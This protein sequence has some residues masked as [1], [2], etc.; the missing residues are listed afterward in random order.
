MQLLKLMETDIFMQFIEL[1]LIDMTCTWKLV[2][3]N[4]QHLSQ[5]ILMEFMIIWTTHWLVILTAWVIQV[6]T[7]LEI[8]FQ[9]FQSSQIQFTTQISQLTLLAFLQ[10]N[11]KHLFLTSLANLVIICQIMIWNVW[12]LHF[13]QM[14]T[15]TFTQ[16]SKQLFQ[17]L[18]LLMERIKQRLMHTMHNLHLLILMV[19]VITSFQAWSIL[20]K[21]ALL[22]LNIQLIQQR[23]IH[24][25]S[26][27][28]TH[29][30]TEQQI[31]LMM[32]LLTALKQ[33]LLNLH[34]KKFNISIWISAQQETTMVLKD[35]LIIQ[36]LLLVQQHLLQ[37]F[38]IE[39]LQVLHIMETPM[40]QCSIQNM[41][42]FQLVLTWLKFLHT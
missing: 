10:D 30:M 42:H 7:S 28:Q 16:E 13:F 17:Q 21:T 18:L 15:E 34:L 41:E 31:M 9:M 24:M 19:M 8:L 1:L 23:N 4:I 2:V 33:H 12:V 29:I 25:W 6:M 35:S 40:W 14:L 39:Q 5:K 3:Q 26:P 22:K 11:M 36:L 37:Q 27:L 38:L 20:T 32:Q